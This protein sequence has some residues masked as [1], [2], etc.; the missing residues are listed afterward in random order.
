MCLLGCILNIYLNE[1][2]FASNGI[3]VIMFIFYKFTFFP[4]FVDY[5]YVFEFKIH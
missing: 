3:V 2:L 1:L 5:L 4:M